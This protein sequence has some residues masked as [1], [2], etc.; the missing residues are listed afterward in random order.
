VTYRVV[1]AVG[2]A[3]QFHHLPTE[4][5]N[6]L[7]SRVADLV[8]AP[9]DEALVLPPGDDPAFRETIFGQGRGLLD[10]YID[11]DAEVVRIFNIVWLG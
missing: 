6:A 11:D 1:L 10:F 2:A 7:V 3:V 9:W 5:Q 8:E 4:A